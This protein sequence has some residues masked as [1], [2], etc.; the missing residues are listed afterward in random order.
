MRKTGKAPS[1]KRRRDPRYDESA[2]RR[3]ADYCIGHGKSL[4]RTMR[5]LGYPKSKE[6]LAGRIDELHPGK[7]KLHGS[8]P[9]KDPAPV[10]TKIKAVAEL[11]ARKGTA[12]EVAERHGVSR[13][14]PCAWRKSIMRD[15]DGATEG[16]GGPVSKEYDDLPDDVE[17]LGRMLADAKTRLRMV[18]LEL[19]VRQSALD[20]LKKTRAP[21]RGC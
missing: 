15:N 13:I 8:K 21:N 3:A 4:S 11:E 9:K 7:R 19:D 14:S 2:R 18:Q 1:G 6:T 20:M 10:E 16:R 12:A 17:E 5:A